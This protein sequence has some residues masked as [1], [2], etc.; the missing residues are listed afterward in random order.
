MPRGRARPPSRLAEMQNE[1]RALTGARSG[2]DVR[3][4]AEILHELI[5]LMLEA[6]EERD[7]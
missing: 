7:G 3:R 6:A 4:I 5:G 2:A 1:L